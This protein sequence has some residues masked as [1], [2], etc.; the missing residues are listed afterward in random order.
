M[1]DSHRSAIPAPSLLRTT[2]EA[3]GALWFVDLDAAALRLS[4]P[5]LAGKTALDGLR[6]GYASDRIDPP[7]PPWLR[8]PAG[9]SHAYDAF[10]AL[11]HDTVRLSLGATDIVQ[12]RRGEALAVVND[13]VGLELSEGPEGTF[14]VTY[15]DGRW[16]EL[17]VGPQ[18][19]GIRFAALRR[20]GG[21]GRPTVEC[22]R[23]PE[24]RVLLETRRYGRPHLRFRCNDGRLVTVERPSESS[25]RACTFAYGAD[26]DL[27]SA[28][29][30][31][32]VESKLATENGRVVRLQDAR[33]CQLRLTYRHPNAF[34]CASVEDFR[35]ECKWHFHS[36]GRGQ[37]V[38]IDA[39]GRPWQFF[40]TSTYL[41][42]VVAPDGT[43]MSREIRIGRG[44]TVVDTTPGESAPSIY[45][46]DDRGRLRKALRNDTVH[47]LSYDT[48]GRLAGYEDP[49]DKR[50]RFGWMAQG[51]LAVAQHLDGSTAEYLRDHEEEISVVSW[52]G[53]ST[54][55][56]YRLKRRENGHVAGFADAERVETWH[57]DDAGYPCGVRSADLTLRL[58]SRSVDGRVE[59]CD[60]GRAR[61][62]VQ[63]DAW[64]RP[65]EL[66]DGPRRWSLYWDAQ[67]V[68]RCVEGPTG[69]LHELD[70]DRRA[71]VVGHR[72]F[73]SVNLTHRLDGRGD[74]VS[75]K[76]GE[77]ELTITRTPAGRIEKLE[78]RAELPPTARGLVSPF[79]APPTA[80]SPHRPASEIAFGWGVDGELESA[81]LDDWVVRIERAQGTV[82]ETQGGHWTQTSAGVDGSERTRTS[83]GLDSTY[84][85]AAGAGQLEARMGAAVVSL[86][87]AGPPQRMDRLSGLGVDER[88]SRDALGRVVR[89]DLS[90]AE[91]LRAAVYT[92][93]GI[94][95]LAS[96]VDGALRRELVHDESG[97]LVASSLG[98]SQVPRRLD[99]HGRSS[100]LDGAMFRGDGALVAADGWT[101]AYDEAGR[102]NR[103]TSPGRIREYDWD[104]HGRLRSVE[105]EERGKR[106]RC[107]Y[108]HDALGRLVARRVSRDGAASNETSFVYR[109][110]RLVHRVT[111]GAVTTWVWLGDRPLVRV[112]PTGELH[113]YITDAAGLPMAMTTASGRL[114]WRGSVDPFGRLLTLEGV[115]TTPD[116][117]FPGYWADEE[118][119][120]LHT[121]FRVF[122][123]ESGVHLDSHPLG[124]AGAPDAYGYLRDPLSEV[125][126]HGL[127]DGG[128]PYLTELLGPTLSRERVAIALGAMNADLRSLCRSPL[129]DPWY[130]ATSTPYERDAA[131]LVT[132][133]VGLVRDRLAAPWRR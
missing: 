3:L 57:V 30:E 15:A 13:S 85:H 51:E 72:G 98:P 45:E 55:T 46:Y 125:S 36:L 53:S 112:A 116:W 21:G 18:A 76:S 101:L 1:S 65:S 61:W 62:R 117:R 69:D 41:R 111:D 93:Q 77:H 12:W 34:L 118:T 9:W 129:P 20:A 70:R 99:H 2:P 16:L 47:V 82:S 39:L 35:R 108:V 86:R 68:L 124:P 84:A 31:Q 80:P 71:R 95:R 78:P 37:Y 103:D 74:I 56:R 59:E 87:L 44:A 122:D 40:R 106:W 97:Y 67:G 27:T 52:A 120:L 94:R 113:R 79:D 54:S 8:T 26:G 121:T 50:A 75:S 10:L 17:E 19:G 123:P 33:G 64:G 25:A 63:R 14:L 115:E 22:I 4:L 60:D 23:D 81:R 105:V 126:P 127:G 73:A 28:T 119:G 89:I 83:L 90:C 24:T 128:L 32:G 43:S 66:H 110:A 7:A 114:A 42:R 29:D 107:D 88:I 49:C 96:E 38:L 131:R 102:R 104:I 109:G 58:V 6:L 133:D 130:P 92:W 5:M 100:A 132:G 48:F 11:T 91:T